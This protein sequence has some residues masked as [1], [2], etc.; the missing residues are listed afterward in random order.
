MGD[1]VNENKA[2]D[3]DST[4]KAIEDGSFNASGVELAKSKFVNIFLEGGL[5]SFGLPAE[6]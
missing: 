4:L 2:E 6:K 3:R 1:E 5:P